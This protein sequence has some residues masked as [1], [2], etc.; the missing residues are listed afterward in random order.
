MRTQFWSNCSSSDSTGSG[1]AWRQSN[2]RSVTRLDSGSDSADCGADAEAV[3]RDFRFGAF[4]GT[5]GLGFLLFDVSA[6]AQS[7]C[8]ARLLRQ[9]A[10]ARVTAP[11]GWPNWWQIAL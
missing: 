2:K 7:D 1:G 11:R 10:S 9:R 6:K 4:A 8:R 5:L 3:A